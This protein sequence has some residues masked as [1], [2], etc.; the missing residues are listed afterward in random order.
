MKKRRDDIPALYND[1]SQSGSQDSQELQKWF[2]KKQVSKADTSKKLSTNC[3][4]NKE[5]KGSLPESKPVAQ[6][7]ASSKESTQIKEADSQTEV[8]ESVTDIDKTDSVTETFIPKKLDFESREE[9]PDNKEA[10]DQNGE[11][12]ED[13]KII[14]Q[15]VSRARK[16]ARSFGSKNASEPEKKK[17]KRKIEDDETESQKRKKLNSS[18]SSDNESIKSSENEEVLSKRVKS[19]ISRLQIDMVRS[20]F[21]PLPNRR[22][23]KLT[24]CV[25]K[26]P[27]CKKIHSPEAKG[28]LRSDVK[29]DVPK[30]LGRPPGDSLKKRARKNSK[31]EAEEE[32]RT[33]RKTL[34]K[35]EIFKGSEASE[36]K[37][38]ESNKD[39]SQLNGEESSVVENFQDSE[40]I[41]E[42]SQDV[43]SKSKLVNRLSEKKLLVKIDKMNSKVKS[44]VQNL[45]PEKVELVDKVNKVEKVEKVEK[46][47]KIEKTES[48]EEAKEP[49]IDV[50]VTFMEVLENQP[51][52][53]VVEMKKPEASPSVKSNLVH[54]SSPK[55]IV[56][57]TSKIKGYS[58]QGR[59]AQMLGLVTK[60][61]LMEKDVKVEDDAQKLLVQV[62]RKPESDNATNAKKGSSKETEK[63][64]NPSGSRQEKIFNNMKSADYC[65]SPPSKLFGSLKNDGEK[66]SPKVAKNSSDSLS[67]EKVMSNEKE[68][69][70][71][72]PTRDYQLPILEW[73]SANPPSLTASPSAGIL[74]RHNQSLP[75]FPGESESMTPNKRKRV[76]F[77]DPPV[78]QKMGYEVATGESPH[79]MNRSSR[80]HSMRRD[81]PLRPRQNRLRMFQMD[82]EKAE[83]SEMPFEE[84]HEMEVDRE[85]SDDLVEIPDDIAFNEDTL[86]KMHEENA[87]PESS[88]PVRV[89]MDKSNEISI[90]DAPAN[91]VETEESKLQSAKLV[92]QIFGTQED[93][94]AAGDTSDDSLKTLNPAAEKKDNSVSLESIKF[95][96]TSDSLSDTAILPKDASKN[97][98]LEDTVD[99]QN[100]SSFDST[101][102]AFCY[103][104]IRCS[105]RTTETEQDT[106]PVTDS[107]F[108]SISQETQ[109]FTQ[110]V[111]NLPNPETLDS[112]ESIFPALTDCTEP[113][114]SIIESL[115]NPLWIHHL[116]SCFASREIHTIGDL[117]RLSER[118]INRIPVKGNPKTEFV[119]SI[120]AK[121]ESGRTRVAA[122]NSEI[123]HLEKV[124][125]LI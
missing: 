83:K 68:T 99:V 13:S 92:E 47:E 39:D 61:G 50:E 49:V 33:N 25:C 19:E 112:T 91:I 78:S 46:M 3:D 17:G 7:E 117:A 62:I 106:L 48:V 1:L 20:V 71:H 105:T 113:V 4:S 18:E 67:S 44:E 12:N 110:N 100:V 66:I 79:K 24:D 80:G 107:V 34:P 87:C 23:S 29:P 26:D 115:S 65:A 118:E 14:P 122:T 86:M 125:N 69:D 116:S 45:E 73:S 53:E 98:N 119:K 42:C 82:V 96:S 16:R 11:E 8:P 56:K 101:D 109:N 5:N 76:S 88:T 85:K 74:K 10:E 102:E 52:S 90:G 75:E 121:F 97:E 63:I 89:S 22:R 36:E 55:G 21:E 51:L 9:F 38:S 123:A 60:Q 27:L 31:Q 72:S 40:E 124:R 120:L 103:K 95:N 30:R 37:P 104:P 28:R 35:L 57:R 81:T 77:A 70:E 59:A 94:F 43:T 54:L 41:V 2:E 32:K 93:M 58:L 15:P 111:A 84:P 64:G 6:P 108:G 114:T